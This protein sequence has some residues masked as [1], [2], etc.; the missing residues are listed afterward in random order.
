[1]SDVEQSRY[2]FQ[3]HPCKLLLLRL[4]KNENEKK[5]LL[6]SIISNTTNVYYNKYNFFSLLYF[7][8]TTK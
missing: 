4:N 1:M 6:F 8:I 7:T 2:P 3:T 5:R